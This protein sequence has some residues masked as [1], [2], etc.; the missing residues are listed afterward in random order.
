MQL[1]MCIEHMRMM[2]LQLKEAQVF[3]VHHAQSNSSSD[4]VNNVHKLML[5]LLLN[6]VRTEKCSH[7][8]QSHIVT[9]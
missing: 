5:S 6:T 9:S 1:L 3:E 2:F 8:L 4:Y 7:K